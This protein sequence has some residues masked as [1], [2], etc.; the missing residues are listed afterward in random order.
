MTT[1]TSIPRIV[2]LFPGQGSQRVGMGKELIDASPIARNLFRRA[3][4]ALGFS[5][6]TLCVEGPSEEL[7]RTEYAQPAILTVSTI[8]FEMLRDQVAFNVVAAAGHSLGEYSALVATGAL[9]FEDAVRIVHRRGTYM[10]SAVPAGIG[11]MAAI[12]G[13]ELSTIEEARARVTTGVVEVA[14]DNSPG[15]IV[16]SGNAAAVDELL[17][18]MAPVKSVELPV[19][20]PFHC[21]LMQPAAELLRADIQNLS[22]R[23]PASPIIANVTAE[24]TQSAAQIKEL[25][26]RQVCGTVRWVESMQ[27]A[28]ALIADGMGPGATWI[29]CGFGTTLA[30]LMKRIDPTIKPMGTQTLADIT[31]VTSYLSGE[32]VSATAPAA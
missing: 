25:L 2:A 16:V 1:S 3:D 6:S 30:G 14:N 26:Y 8:C 31:A 21:S 15:Q 23:D 10:Q 4:D 27:R 7:T 19:S 5:L 29:E 22:L 24:P 20:A 17:K 13:K 28:R 32:R 11:K 9:D 18:L 12:L